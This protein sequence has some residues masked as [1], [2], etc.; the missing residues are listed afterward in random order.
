MSHPSLLEYYTLHLSAE[1]F[2]ASHS[3][4]QES[5]KESLMTDTYGRNSSELSVTLSQLGLLG[6]MLPGCFQCLTTTPP[7]QSRMK[8]V[9]G[10]RREKFI[11][12]TMQLDLQETSLKGKVLA[13][14]MKFWK[15][16]KPLDTRS[17]RI[18]IQLRSSGLAT[19]GNGSLSLP[20]LTKSDATMGDLNGKEF[21][22]Q[23]RHA[24]KVGNALAMLPTPLGA[25][26]NPAAHGQS[27]GEWKQKINKRLAMLPTCTSRDHKGGTVKR[28]EDGN[29]KRALD[30]EM[31][32]RG[33]KLQ[34][35]FAEWMMGLPPG[36]TALDASG[37]PSS[38]NKSTRSSKQLRVLKEV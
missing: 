2:H 4:A 37:M 10:L 15:K 12:S 17:K 3:H 24:M 11:L 18:V 26:T 21:S 1:D 30:C 25:S 35:A 9:I 33:L 16:L 36:W 22:G 13:S 27:N 34:P 7:P 23:N 5:K 6:R 14:S 8:Q 29:P 31:Q 19:S 38:R 28:V 20:T 32:V